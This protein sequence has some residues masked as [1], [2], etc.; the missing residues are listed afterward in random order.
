MNYPSPG[1]GAADQVSEYYRGFDGLSGDGRDTGPQVPKHT[2]EW[3]KAH[4]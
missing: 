1:G 2:W 3:Y 4:N